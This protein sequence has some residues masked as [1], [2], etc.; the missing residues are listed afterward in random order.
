M[1]RWNHALC[2]DCWDE[3]EPARKAHRIVLGMR[4]EEMC[5]R[6][7]QTTDSGIYRR[8]DPEEYA[9]RGVHD[10]AGAS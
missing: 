3:L 2:D 9:C 10:E 1:S 7:E 6:C 4:V 5:C 8:G